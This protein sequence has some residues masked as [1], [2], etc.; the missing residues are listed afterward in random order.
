MHARRQEAAQA[1]QP[2]ASGTERQTDTPKGWARLDC[3][4]A[5]LQREQRLIDL[6][7]LCTGSSK[8]MHVCV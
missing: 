8:C 1:E 3:T 6:R 7:A 5:L 2:T 4:N